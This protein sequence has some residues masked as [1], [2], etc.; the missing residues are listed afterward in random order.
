MLGLCLIVF[1]SFC[2]YLLFK[3]YLKASSV[4]SIMAAMLLFPLNK[5]L[6]TLYT[7]DNWLFIT[8]YSILPLAI[9]AGIG[10]INREKNSILICA[11]TLSL[12]F[13]L[14]S[15]HPN[16]Y[17]ILVAAFFAVMVLLAAEQSQNFREFIGKI[18]RVGAAILI[19]LLFS[20][21]YLLPII[22][23]Y[24]TWNCHVIPHN[25]AH[26]YRHC[27]KEIFIAL[28]ALLATAYV[29]IKKKKIVIGVYFSAAALVVC[30]MMKKTLLMDFVMVKISGGINDRFT[31]LLWFLSCFMVLYYARNL[32]HKSLNFILIL[33]SVGGFS[34]FTYAYSPSFSAIFYPKQSYHIFLKAE[35]ANYP[36]LS[37]DKSNANYIKEKILK[38]EKDFDQEGVFEKIKDAKSGDEIIKIANAAADVIDNSYAEKVNNFDGQKFRAAISTY[39]TSM[40]YR[41]LKPFSRIESSVGHDFHIGSGPG[42][43]LNNSSTSFDPRYMV[44]HIPTEFLYVAKN[45]EDIHH[46][47]DGGGSSYNSLPWVNFNSEHPKTKH[48]MNVSGVDYVTSNRNLGLKKINSFNL[49]GSTYHLYQNPSSYGVSYIA[50]VKNNSSQEDVVA[51]KNV[52][53]DYVGDKISYKDYE[54]GIKK[55]EQQIFAL[56]NKYDAIVEDNSDMKNNSGQGVSE[57]KNIIGNIIITRS[58]CQNKDC[59]LALNFAHFPQ[60]KAFRPDFSELKIYDVNL[61]FMGVRLGSGVHEVMF[62]YLSYL[63]E[64]CII[65]SLMMVALLILGIKINLKNP[66]L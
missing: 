56:H 4:I 49:F 65:L 51:M 48:M 24:L 16:Y 9:M 34:Y 28:F 29:S 64:V 19:S 31:M 10:V 46:K 32:C 7:F 14:I 42:L 66:F 26:C 23:K 5:V 3:K 11:F 43:L 6:I 60:W 2:T 59:I 44:G 8:C 27:N 37:G 35:L 15:V 36:A 30:Y 61:A 22:E 20:A 62:I 13:L 53:K 58:T 38:Y 45:Y 39:N 52:V 50:N 57:I 33:I 47:G 12:P 55:F 40:I 21:Y 18:A 63:D 17:I 25:S 41:G 1:G 54:D